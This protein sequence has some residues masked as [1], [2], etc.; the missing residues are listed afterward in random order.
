[1]N[2]ILQAR[3]TSFSMPSAAVAVMAFVC[4][5][6]SSWAVIPNVLPL[7]A[8]LGMLSLGLYIWSEIL[9]GRIKRVTKAELLFGL[10]CLWAAASMSWSVDAKASKGL[11]F[12]YASCLITFAAVSRVSLKPRHWRMIGWS[13]VFGIMVTA[14]IFLITAQQAAGNGRFGIE[15]IN[16][17]YIAYSI[18]TAFPVLFMLMAEKKNSLRWKIFSSAWMGICILTVLYTGSRGAIISVFLSI[19]ALLFPANRRHIAKFVLVLAA[20]AIY[21]FAIVYFLP[22]SITSRLGFLSILTGKSVGSVDLSYRLDN[23]P[24]A[25]ALFYTNVVRGIGVGAYE[26]VSPL[27]LRVHN[28][29]LSLLVELG[30][31]GFIL[32]FLVI[33]EIFI[34]VI[35]NA[36]NPLIRRGGVVLLM[37]WLPIAMSGAWEVSI[38]AWLVF[39]WFMGATSHPAPVRNQLFN[40]TPKR[41]GVVDEGFVDPTHA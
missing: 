38:V 29:P 30:V 7:P 40:R 19:V 1:M 21:F 11:A 13:F 14:L 3:A 4:V 34:T 31:I 22:D 39:A 9:R 28:I 36:K 18:A 33:Y 24:F 20:F 10:F 12:Q 8:A 37:G 32:Y 5:W 35:R 15:D 17:N 16:A 41:S 26:H 2:N 6:T 27:N 23:W 25:L